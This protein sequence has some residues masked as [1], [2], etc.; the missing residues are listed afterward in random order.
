MLLLRHRRDVARRHENAVIAAAKFLL[1]CGNAI[2]TKLVGAPDGLRARTALNTRASK[3]EVNAG[4]GVDFA[5][6]GARRTLALGAVGL[7][8]LVAT[9]AGAA[10]AQ[11]VWPLTPEM[12]APWNAQRVFE[13]VPFAPRWGVSGL[14]EILPEDT[15]VKTRL[16]EGYEPVGV[17]AGTWMFIP[18][19]TIGGL[20]TSNAFAT[21]T[22]KQSDI[23]LQ[24]RPMLRAYTLWEG[25]SLE[26]Q[27]DAQSETYKRNPRLD[28][29]DASFKGRGKFEIGHDAAILTNFRVAQLHD[30]VGSL[31][32][33]AGAVE[34]TPYTY[35]LGD[36]TYWKRFNRLSVS[37]G[38]RIESYDYG[39]TRAQYGSII[40][41]SSRDGQIYTGHGRVEYVFTPSFGIF[42]AVEGNRREL[43]GTPDRPLSSEGY[44]ALAGVS[45]ELSRLIWGEVGFGYADQ[46]FD[47]PAIGP[48]TGPAYRA[49]L[50]WRPTRTVDVK[51]KAESIITQAVDTDATGIRADNLQMSVDYEFRR[52]VIFSLGLIYEKDQFIGLTR[53][54]NVYATL[55]EVRY[56]LNRHWTVS[57]RH[58]YTNRD[59]NIPTST[60]DKHEIGLNVAAQF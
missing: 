35:I 18:S 5:W 44:R 19:L 2:R 48:V 11:V 14:E 29:L 41:Q 37:T 55:A 3:S 6:S 24:V 33:P 52:N 20:Y 1:R 12:E 13:T 8:W 57:L 40:D 47:S 32:S 34:P 31:T 50:V 60:Y 23:A 22:N 45:F 16:H 17:R 26:L 21:P 58:Q 15:P 43:R 27:A 38:A 49:Q 36:A 28:S 56:L 7:M 54:D 30:A 51:F 53:K 42:G 4:S 9:G 25:N 46:Q 39:S 10:R 59:S